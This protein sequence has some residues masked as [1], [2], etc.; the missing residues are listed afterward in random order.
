[1]DV[2]AVECHGCGAYLPDAVEIATM[3]RSHRDEDRDNPLGTTG[4][5]T[6]CGNM[7]WTAGLHAFIQV[8]LNQRAAIMN[9][10]CHLRIVNPHIELEDDSSA[11]LSTEALTYPHEVGSYNGTMSR[12][13][14]GTNVYAISWG[15]PAQEASL[16]PP[17]HEEVLSYWPGG[18]GMLDSNSIPEKGYYIAGSFNDWSPALMER[19]KSGTYGYYLTLGDEGIAKFQIWLDG[20]P[21]R[22]LHP[23]Y[24]Q[25]Q[26][27][28]LV[29]GPASSEEATGLVWLICGQN[30]QFGNPGD[31][32]HVILQVTGVWRT[33]HWSLASKS[34]IELSDEEIS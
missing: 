25:A 16:T 10:L 12:G 8:L 26:P 21:E 17:V 33:V 23:N 11:L 31:Q 15:A 3:M 30:F 9:P 29:Q 27:S 18:G 20:N 1:L 7:V 2:D 5:K 32:Y 34:G 6:S 22:T 4:V 19:V 14:G 13:L 24:P 28:S